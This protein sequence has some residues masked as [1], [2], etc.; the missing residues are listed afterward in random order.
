ML[1]D[2]IYV[3]GSS[4]V[5]FFLFTNALFQISAI[6]DPKTPLQRTVNIIYSAINLIAAILYR[7]SRSQYA[8]EKG[9]QKYCLVASYVIVAIRNAIRLIDFEETRYVFTILEFF[10]L[11]QS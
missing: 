11:A 10:Y 8:T 2:K 5:L 9:I 7:L 3:N 1:W 4:I 6:I